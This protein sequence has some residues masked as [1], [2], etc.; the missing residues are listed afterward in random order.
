MGSLLPLAGWVRN[1][2]LRSWPAL[3]FMLTITVPPLAIVVYYDSPGQSTLTAA[4]WILAAYF[5]LAWLALIAALVQPGRLPLLLLLGVIPLSVVTGLPLAL[6]LEGV[7]HDS[8]TTIGGSIFTVGLPEELAKAIPVI[9]VAIA[10]RRRVAPAGYLFLGAVSGLAFGACEVQHYLGEG[11][12]L[13][14][15]DPAQAVMAALQYVWRFPTDPITHACWAGITG[16]FI[17]RAVHAKR[18]SGRRNWYAVCW[19]GLALAVGLHGLSDWS[20][21]DGHWPWIGVGA[22][23]ALLFLGYAKAEPHAVPARTPGEHADEA[24]LDERD[25]H[26]VL[27]LA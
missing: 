14:S 25:V 23:S 22:V 26:G 4:G 12:G 13:A 2:A 19:V 8:T 17:G 15:G 3:L 5:A 9:A 11:A 24:D 10:F 20:T 16:Y 6:W 1:P 7:L 18:K 21:V 27:S